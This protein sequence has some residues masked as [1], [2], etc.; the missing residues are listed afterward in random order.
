M[1]TAANRNLHSGW[2][3]AL[4]SRS[5]NPTPPSYVDKRWIRRLKNPNSL[6]SPSK[7][8]LA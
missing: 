7:R 2:H 1:N 8:N 3:R 4:Q 6:Y 5:G